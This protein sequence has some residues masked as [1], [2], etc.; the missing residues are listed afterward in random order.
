MPSL[1]GNRK[2]TPMSSS[3]LFT[4][5]TY[6]CDYTKISRQN[7]A[8]QKKLSEKVERALEIRFEPFG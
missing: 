3:S 4:L 6:V 5:F 1:S 2:N 8:L 7:Q